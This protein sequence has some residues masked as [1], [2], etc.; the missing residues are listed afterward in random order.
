MKSY[1]HLSLSQRYQIAASYRNGISAQQIAVQLARDPTTIRRELKRCEPGYYTPEQAHRH[2][3]QSR[4]HR[5]AYKL[6]P[7]I[8]ELV[9]SLLTQQHSPEQVCGRLRLETGLRLS[10]MSLYRLIYTDADA[11]G[12]LWAHMRSTRIK[13]KP[14]T[15]RTTLRGCIKNRV[16]IHQRDPVVDKVER[17]GDLELDTIIGKARKGVVATVTDR[18]SSYIWMAACGDKQAWPLSEKVKKVLRPVSDNLHTITSDNGLEFAEHH[19]IS[20]ALKVDYYFADPYQTNQRARIEHA[21]KLIRQYLPKSWDLRGIT[22][23]E[24]NPIEHKLNHRPRKKLGFKTPHEV[25]FNTT[26]TLIKHRALQM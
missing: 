11:G 15:P 12:T 22:R 8:I 14:R 13:P 9:S 6:T 23:R 17:I 16:S 21:N 26:E 18:L 3:R 2:Y 4:K 25:F 7:E 10:P 24:L 20:H 5:P 1:K 19:R